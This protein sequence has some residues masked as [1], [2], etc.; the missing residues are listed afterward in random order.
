MKMLHKTFTLTV[1]LNSSSKLS[2]LGKSCF[3]PFHFFIL[4]SALYSSS[5]FRFTFY[6]FALVFVFLSVPW[7]VGQFALIHSNPVIAGKFV[8]S[9]DMRRPSWSYSSSR[10]H[11]K[12]CPRFSYV[13]SDN[14]AQKNLSLFVNQGSVQGLQIYMCDQF[15]S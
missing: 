6:F 5:A 8:E 12:L 4:S 3:L 1:H 15:V 10:C 9:S 13:L 2:R 14:F 11:A 7:C